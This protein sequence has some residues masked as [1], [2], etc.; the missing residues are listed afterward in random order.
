MAAI[1]A[2]GEPDLAPDR[3]TMGSMLAIVST[4]AERHIQQ[5]INSVPRNRVKCSRRV[6]FL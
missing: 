3:V 6:Y 4:L 1:T 5:S 2:A